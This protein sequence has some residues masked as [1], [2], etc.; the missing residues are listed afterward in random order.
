M[1]NAA[2]FTAL[3]AL[4]PARLWHCKLCGPRHSYTQ[5][6]KSAQHQRLLHVPVFV[7]DVNWLHAAVRTAC[8]VPPSCVFVSDASH[9]FETQDV[10]TPTA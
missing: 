4:Q 7:I 2:V 10:Q 6:A 9:E 1:C 5:T 8:C 3:Q